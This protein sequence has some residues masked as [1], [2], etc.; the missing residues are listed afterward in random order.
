M[1]SRVS[2]DELK[3]IKSG[4]R[5]SITGRRSMP[6]ERKRTTE[7]EYFYKKEREL[8]EKLRQRAALEAERGAMGESLGVADERIL[9]DLQALGFTRDTVALLHLVPLVAVAWA[10]GGIDK[11]ERQLIYE[12]AKLRGIESGGAAA[13]QLDGWLNRRPSDEFF[14]RSLRI[15]RAVLKSLPQEA[16]QESRQSLVAYCTRIAAASGG[17][18]GLGSKISAAES[19]L[20]TK[21]ATELEE[22]HEAAAKQIIS[23]T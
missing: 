19:A 13:K 17:I 10:E 3:Y 7:E 9:E 21:I 16:Q 8:V 14:E 15:I 22:G 18:L 5:D 4:S 11:R 23:G 20:L 12:V 1:L 6:E 2:V